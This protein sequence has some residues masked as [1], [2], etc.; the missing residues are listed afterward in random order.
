MAKRR[1]KARKSKARKKSSTGWS[2]AKLTAYK[3]A[4]RK[5]INAFKKKGAKG[6]VSVSVG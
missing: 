4:K 2:A 1:K 6:S 3:R 5:L